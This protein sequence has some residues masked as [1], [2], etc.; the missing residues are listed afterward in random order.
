[1]ENLS[2]INV[3]IDTDVDD[4]EE[5]KRDHDRITNLFKS[6]A[7]SKQSLD[8]S[9]TQFDTAQVQHN[10]AMEQ[11]RTLVTGSRTEDMEA[12]KAQVRQ[13]G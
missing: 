3:V 2:R 6:G 9:Q 1:M 12:M 5:V 7:V 10:M 11:R 4:Q 13:A 8:Q